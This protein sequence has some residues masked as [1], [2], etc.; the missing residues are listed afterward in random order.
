MA[1]MQNVTL[2]RKQLSRREKET[3]LNQ[4]LIIGTAAVLVLVLVVLG[5]GVVDQFVL[6]PRQPVVVVAGEEVQV[7]QYQKLV[8]YRRW[9]YRNYINYLESQRMQAAAGGEDSAFLVQHFE[10]QIE[11]LQMQ[12]PNIPSQVVEELIDDLIVRHEAGQRGLAV[13]DEEVQ[14]RIEEQFGYLRNPPTPAPTPVDAVEQGDEETD[15]GASAEAPAE[16]PTEEPMTYE[17]Y[18]ERSEDWF[19]AMREASGFTQHDFE[20]LIEGAI[21]REKLEEQLK[22][23]VPTTGEQ[24][25]ARHI[26]VETQEEAEEVLARLN[27]GEPF[28]AVATEVSLDT[29]NK[30]DGG[31][32]GWF[33]R[34]QMDPAFEEAAFA[35][36]PGEISDVVETTF[37][38]HII[39]VE[40]RDPNREMDEYT[41][42]QAQYKA[43]ESWFTAQREM[44]PIERH[45]DSSMVPEDRAPVP[46][47]L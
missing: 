19:S 12:E 46:A 44:L 27:A 40:D 17:E 45:W 37:G 32:L 38:Y 7:D 10:Q 11:Q 20:Q 18:V 3:R 30:D 14:I 42:E 47:G 1:K 24:I 22:A 9:D 29:S 31:D 23:D 35:L 34:G 25:H 16:A 39:Q 15:A 21:L 36:E 43:I 6:R 13:T 4:R 41:L 33:P 8:R 5:W 28:E 26:L 2:N